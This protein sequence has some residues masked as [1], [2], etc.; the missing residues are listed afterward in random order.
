MANLNTP[1]N[2][3]AFQ[4][5]VEGYQKM[6]TN[7]NKQFNAVFGETAK[8]VTKKN[9]ILSEVKRILSNPGKYL[10]ETKKKYEQAK[11]QYP[12]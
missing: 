2:S 4:K 1:F 8:N 9:G 5:E 3:V 7:R 11:K 6:Y 10:T 12:K